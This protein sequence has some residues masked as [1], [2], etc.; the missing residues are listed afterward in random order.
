MGRNWD[1]L[2]VG[3]D[4]REEEDKGDAIFLWEDGGLAGP[5]KYVARVAT[6]RR[7]TFRVESA[8]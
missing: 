7:L 5:G 1:K 6:R 2:D 8:V 4:W 3:F